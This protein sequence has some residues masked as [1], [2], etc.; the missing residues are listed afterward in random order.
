MQINGIPDI[1]LELHNPEREQQY[2][3]ILTILSQ[4]TG[5]DPEDLRH[6]ALLVLSTALLASDGTQKMT[7]ALT[8]WQ[9]CDV[10]GC[11][12]GGLVSHV[13]ANFALPR[14]Q[15]LTTH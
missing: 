14:M 3:Q 2:E 6:M 4:R 7:L 8:H 9:R 13:V 12:C 5:M 15:P 11:G 1:N 10:M